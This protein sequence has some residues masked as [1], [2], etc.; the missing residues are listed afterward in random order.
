MKQ[1]LFFQSLRMSHVIERSR[2]KYLDSKNP[3]LSLFYYYYEN[4]IYG[5]LNLHF[6]TKKIR[7]QIKLK[8]KFKH[9]LLFDEEHKYFFLR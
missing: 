8:K 6:S 7:N 3:N 9:D 1:V 2:Y 5:P 4:N